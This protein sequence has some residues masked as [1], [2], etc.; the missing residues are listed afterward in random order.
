MSTPPIV[1]SFVGTGSPLLSDFIENE[2]YSDVF[3][4]T[5]GISYNQ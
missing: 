2:N 1:I 4:G 3:S 5:I